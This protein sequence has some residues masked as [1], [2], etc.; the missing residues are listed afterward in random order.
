MSEIGGETALKCTC[1]KNAALVRIRDRGP[2]VVF[3][4]DQVMGAGLKMHISLWKP[5]W[6]LYGCLVPLATS[7]MRLKISVPTSAMV[8]SPV[9]M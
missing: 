6:S 3:R 4:S 5:Y 9:A 2:P 8:A 1:T 7:R